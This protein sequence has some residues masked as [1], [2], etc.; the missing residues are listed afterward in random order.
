MLLF[1]KISST[2]GNLKVLGVRLGVFVS[3][4]SISFFKSLRQLFVTFDSTTVNRFNF[5]GFSWENFKLLHPW[6]SLD[7][8][9]TPK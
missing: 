5:F 6:G 1:G 8:Y 4:L 9:S 3:A 7:V 2:A